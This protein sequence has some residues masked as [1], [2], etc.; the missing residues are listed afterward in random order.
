MSTALPVYLAMT[1]AEFCNAEALPPHPAWMAC[2]FSCYGTGLSNLPEH[3]PPGSMLILNDRTPVYKHDPEL[4]SRQLSDFV[5]RNPIDSILLDF[6]R[7][8][9]DQTA[10]IANAIISA[11]DCPVGVTEAYANDFTCPVFLSPPPLYKPLCE[12]LSQWKERD[13]WLEVALDSQKIT[14][15]PE[16]SHISQPFF[17]EPEEPSFPEDALFCHYHA[18]VFENEAVFTLFR[19]QEMLKTL[20]QEAERLGVCKAVGLYQELGNK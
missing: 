13:I 17:A 19:T 3:L 16:G 6:Q 20:L 18:E 4:I 15:T 5:A 1:A 2:H 8:D 9:C 14:V 7:C 10:D 12:Y 11:L